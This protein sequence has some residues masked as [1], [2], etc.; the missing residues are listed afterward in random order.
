MAAHLWPEQT[1]QLHHTAEQLDLT[2]AAVSQ[3]VQR[4]ERLST[5]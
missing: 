2:Q 1:G 3:H 5:C 4:L